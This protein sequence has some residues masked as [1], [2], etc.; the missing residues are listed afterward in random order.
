MSRLASLACIMEPRSLVMSRPTRPNCR[1]S[2]AQIVEAH[3][4]IMSKLARLLA[5][6]L[7]YVLAQSPTLDNT[8]GSTSIQFNKEPK[9]SET[10]EET[11]LSQHARYSPQPLGGR[12]GLL[13]PASHYMP[14]ELTQSHSSFLGAKYLLFWTG[15]GIMESG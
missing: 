3:S 5:R 2:L 14:Y 13:F 4:L 15:V 8:T 1:G 7:P 12:V 6:Q 10:A 11:L 9:S